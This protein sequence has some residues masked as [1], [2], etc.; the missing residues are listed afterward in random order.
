MSRNPGISRRRLLQTAGAAAGA[1][2][3]RGAQV[4][5][6]AGRRVS[7]RVDE[8]GAVRVTTATLEATIEEGFLTS[9]RSRRSGEEFLREFDR[10]ASDA[11]QLVFRDGETTDVG[12]RRFGEVQARPVS[13]GRAEVVFH[14]WNGDGVLAIS[15]DPETGDLLL[16]PSAFSS[17]PGAR[18]CRWLLKGIGRQLRLVAPFFQGVS[19]SLDDPLIRNTHWEWPRAWEAGLAILEGRGGG[20]W[21]HT[22]DDRYRYKSLKVGLSGEPHVLGFDTEVYGPIDGNLAAGGLVWRINVYDGDWK[23]P[24]ERYRSWL[25]KAYGLARQEAARPEW[26]G[27]LRMAISWCPGELDIL[28]ALAERTDP[29]KVLIHFPHWRTDPYDENYPTYEPSENA[30]RFIARAL[31]L[32]FHVMPHFNSLEVDPGNPVY[33]TVRDFAYRHIETK[34]LQGWSWV[35][36]RS[37]GVPE[38]NRMRPRYRDKKVMVKIPR[39]WRCGARSCAAGSRRPPG[40]SRSARSSAT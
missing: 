2:R 8:R 16:E 10:A 17:R 24:A 18:A 6:G 22:R 1:A 27:G 26:L 35:N 11:L 14:G 39:A 12:E 33:E 19:L 34:K 21:I 29:R 25:W 20:F 31:D 7:V 36:R 5:V 30:K 32:G 37:I 15:A 28:E 23:V 40:S 4:S 38:S 13:E 9:L 3:L